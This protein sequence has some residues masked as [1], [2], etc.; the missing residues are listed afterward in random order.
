MSNA[1]YLLFSGSTYYPGKAF[2]DFQGTFASIEEALEHQANNPTDW[3]QIVSA[4]TWLIV[5]ESE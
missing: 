3:W 1:P 4:A 2:R 5:R